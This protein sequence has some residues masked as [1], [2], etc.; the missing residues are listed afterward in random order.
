MERISKQSDVDVDIARKVLRW[1]TYAKEPLRA[2]ALQH[3]VAITPGMKTIDDGDLTDV[4]DLISLCAG[5]VTVDRESDIVRLVH[6]T[7]YDY[8]GKQLMNEKVDIARDCLTYLG[9]EVFRKDCNVWPS[10]W[11]N[12]ALK[13]RLGKYPFVIYAVAHWSEHLRGNPEDELKD[14]FF[15]AFKWQGLRDSVCQIQLH[16]TKPSDPLNYARK[17]T[18]L[19]IIAA[20]GLSR[21]CRRLLDEGIEDYQLY[22]CNMYEG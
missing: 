16:L 15:N 1:I 20:S 10:P 22:I 7:T 18:V 13:D 21:L 3:A 5:I 12:V 9:L 19:H 17:S 6:Y 4:D 2:K 11:K 14:R 8:L